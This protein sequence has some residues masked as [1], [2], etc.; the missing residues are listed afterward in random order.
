MYEDLEILQK[1]YYLKN[2]LTDIN[3]I[4]LIRELISKRKIEIEIKDSHSFSKRELSRM[5]NG[6]RNCYFES[7]NYC[8]EVYNKEADY[9]EEFEKEL[10]L[11]F[12]E[13]EILKL[14]IHKEKNTTISRVAKESLKI[15]MK[16]KFIQLILKY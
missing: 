2:V 9:S 14:K 16:E 13:F 7:V 4:Q 12:R 3:E 11:L 5:T 6:I 10:S 1:L 8:I 15:I